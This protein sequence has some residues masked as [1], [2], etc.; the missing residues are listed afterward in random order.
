MKRRMKIALLDLQKLLL[1][2]DDF[3]EVVKTLEK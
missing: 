1:G 3:Y 2:T